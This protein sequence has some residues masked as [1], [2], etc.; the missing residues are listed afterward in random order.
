MIVY[1]FNPNY[2]LISDNVYFSVKTIIA[3]MNDKAGK[4]LKFKK[5]SDFMKDANAYRSIGD[6]DG[7]ILTAEIGKTDFLLARKEVALIAESGKELLGT[8][9]F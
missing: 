4:G 8:V 6:T 1:Y 5:I 9:Y 7:V 3:L 2:V